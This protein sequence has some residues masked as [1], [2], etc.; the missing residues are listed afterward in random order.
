MAA[1]ITRVFRFLRYKKQKPARQIFYGAVRIFFL[2]VRLWNMAG[3]TGKFARYLAFLP[4][5]CYKEHDDV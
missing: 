2:S 1:E 5:V 3:E 4:L